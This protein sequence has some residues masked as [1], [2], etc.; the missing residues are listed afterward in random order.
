MMKPIIRI[1]KQLIK[2]QQITKQQYKTLFELFNEYEGAFRS[3]PAIHQQE[4]FC[5]SL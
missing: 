2:K 1:T 5:C 3:L 4:F